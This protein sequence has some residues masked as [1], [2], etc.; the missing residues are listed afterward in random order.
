MR[1]KQ[2][3]EERPKLEGEI[4]ALRS[5]NLSKE[6][7]VSEGHIFHTRWPS[8]SI[9]EKRELVELMV[10]KIVVG[11]TE[12]TLSYCYAPLSKEL[13]QRQRAL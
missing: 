4:S 11:E 12:V 9:D 13:P 10:E 1:R 7:L 6:H 8:M 3:D 2:I 5:E